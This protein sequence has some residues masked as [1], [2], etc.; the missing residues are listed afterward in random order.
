V[1]D[2]LAPTTGPVHLYYGKDPRRKYFRLL[3]SGEVKPVG[4]YTMYFAPEQAYFP[5]WPPIPPECQGAGRDQC[6]SCPEIL[7]DPLFQFD[8]VDLFLAAEQV[9]GRMEG[10]IR[11]A[12]IK[13]VS[14][15]CDCTTDAD[16]PADQSEC[17]SA[18]AEGAEPGCG[19]PVTRQSGMCGPSADCDP[20]Y[21]GA[22]C[23]VSTPFGDC[24]STLSCERGRLVCLA[25]SCVP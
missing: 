7:D 10:S 25:E 4:R 22:D 19:W 16:C 6:G 23:T 15:G 17:L 24:E 3:E 9:T 20:E 5:R 18:L 11:L 8:I 14:S 13:H 21:V 1:F 2:I 12:A